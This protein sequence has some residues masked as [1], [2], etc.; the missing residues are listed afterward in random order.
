MHANLLKMIG[1]D[2]RL[3][4]ARADYDTVCLIGYH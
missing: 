2:D 3:A 4:S 1:L